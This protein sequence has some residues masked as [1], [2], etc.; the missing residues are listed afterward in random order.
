MLWLKV[1]ELSRISFFHN[2]LTMSWYYMKGVCPH[3]SCIP[4][5]RT[6]TI[7]PW[8][9]EQK[10]ENSK[11]R[12][13]QYIDLINVVLETYRHIQ[14]VETERQ[15][16]SSPPP[17]LSFQSTNIYFCILVQFLIYPLSLSDV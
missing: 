9:D 13:L 10:W 15:P 11:R 8:L 12:V 2:D 14:S 16:S 1:C 7:A 3:L 17:H 5:H 6:I 4:D